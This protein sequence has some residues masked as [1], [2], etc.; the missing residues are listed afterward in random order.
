MDL[1]FAAFVRITRDAGLR[2]LLVNHADRID[3][4]RNGE[5]GA[6]PRTCFLALRWAPVDPACAPAGSAEVLTASVHLPLHRCTEHLFLDFVLERLRGALAA[7]TTDP[8][9]TA[10]CLGTSRA[11][12]DD[13]TDTIVK[14]ATFEITPAGPRHA[15]VA[16]RQLGPWPAALHRRAGHF[17]VIEGTPGVN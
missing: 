7:E 16:P 2:S 13:R 4:E 1:R 15:G 9:V 6:A 12:V 5:G 14:T 17:E 8:P 10:R 11:V 3:H